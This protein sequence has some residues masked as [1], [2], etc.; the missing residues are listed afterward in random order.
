MAGTLERIVQRALALSAWGSLMISGGALMISG[1]DLGRAMEGAPDGTALFWLGKAV[2]I[3]AGVALFGLW[4]FAVWHAVLVDPWPYT[5]PRPF[6][7]GVVALTTVLG[8]LG[9][10][11]L[12]EL[13]RKS[14]PSA[15]RAPEGIGRETR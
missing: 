10:Y 11:F 6:V 14:S 9:Y 8:G 4:I 1:S 13:W 12:A 5:V 15:E 7:V 3:V 2:A